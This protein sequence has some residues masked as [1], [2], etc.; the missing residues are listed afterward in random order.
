MKTKIIAGIGIAVLVIGLLFAIKPKSFDKQFDKKMSNMNSYILS[1]NMEITKGED[2]KTYAVEVGY[3]KDDKDLFKVT[4]TDK[5]L[6]QQ[7][8][9]LRNKSGVYVITPSLNQIFKFEGD[10]PMNSP[11]PYL[12]QSIA[13]IVKQKNANIKKESDGYLVSSKVSYPNNKDYDHEE[14]M[15]DKDAKVKWLQIYNKDNSAQLKIVFTKSDYDATIK[16]EYFKAPTTI[17][18][19][20]SSSAINEADLPLYPV[21]VYNSTLTNTSTMDINGSVKHVLEYTGDKNFTV[22]EMKRTSAEETQTVIMPGKMIDALDVVGFYDG[23]HMS[24]IYDNVEF[25]VF[26]EDLGPDE[27]MEVINSMQVAVMK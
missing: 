6:N 7:Q 14:I 5:E 21:M 18:K 11:K 3:K 20:A 22:V 24:V 1:G 23:N 19:N 4:I 16:D 15:F 25:T 17:E 12:L 2:V 27:M 9:I 8:I 26:S 10:W 13:S